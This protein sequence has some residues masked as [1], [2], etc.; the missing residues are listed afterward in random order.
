MLALLFWTSWWILCYTYLI[1]GGILWLLTR[2]KKAEAKEIGSDKLFPLT[3]VIAA[4]NEEDFIE[5][6]IQNTLSL[7]YPKE[8]LNVLVVTDGSSDL[9]PELARRHKSIRVFH[10]PERRG[11]I[12]AVHRIM[13]YVD[14]PITVY[15]DA[16]TLLNDDA[17]LEIA[18]SF[19]NPEVGVV[20]GEKKILI[21]E[22]A[23]ASTAGEGLYWKYESTLK[24]MD[25]ELYSAVGAAGELF[26]IR[27][28]MYEAVPSDTIIEDFYMT[29]KI[30][31]KGYKIAYTPKAY[32]QEEGSADVGEEMKRKIRIAAGAFQAMKRLGYF[33]SPAKFPLL[34]FQYV[35]HRVMRWTAAPLSLVVLLISHLLLAVNVGGWYSLSVIPHLAFYCMALL[36][37]QLEKKKLK[38]KVFFVPFYF[39]MMNYC[40]FLGFAK[41]LRGKQQV[42]W[43]RAKRK[44]AA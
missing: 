38:W 18:K 43:E 17:L 9:T 19:Q 21:P 20:S 40:M 29:M 28:D 44:M 26:A 10:E 42:T 24:R 15:T 12:A 30:A 25:A 2:G 3:V 34:S 32:A 37:Y 35:S 8:Y 11:K 6:K 7:N 4:Y 1:Y 23:D 31:L 5:E 22:E 27:T 13:R 41:Y 36:G 39:L 14:T 33:L 16:N